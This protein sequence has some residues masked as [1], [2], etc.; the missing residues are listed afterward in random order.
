MHGGVRVA[1]G[2]GDFAQAGFIR[3]N[4]AFSGSVDRNDTGHKVR[5]SG[6]NVAVSF[7]A[8]DEALRD[9]VSEHALQFLL[10]AGA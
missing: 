1:L 5:L 9:E 10:L 4:E 7:G 2:H 8:Q 3:L 6:L